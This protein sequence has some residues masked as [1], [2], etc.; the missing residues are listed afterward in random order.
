M[1]R[2]TIRRGPSGFT[3]VELLVVIGIIA[4]LISILLPALNKAR[5]QANSVKCA[6]NMR[7]IYTYVQ[8]YVQDNKGFLP[9]PPP[10][11]CTQAASV[12]PMGY[13]MIVAGTVDLTA[14]GLTEYMAPNVDARLALFNC[15]TDLADARPVSA[16][17]SITARNF[18]YSFN[19][20]LDYN[21]N[22]GYDDTF[23]SLPRH[24][25]I[26]IAQIRSAAAKILIFEEKW[27]NDG[28]CQITSPTSNTGTLDTNDVPADRHT[29]YGNQCFADGHVDRITPADFYA[30]VNYSG[31]VAIDVDW[32]HLLSY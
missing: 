25:T 15:P 8:M 11:S 29:G 26:N 21:F 23:A 3:L 4:M 32:F 9:I 30:H 2:G 27:P 19:G 31:N 18:T 6:S 24:Q 28:S 17:T 22:G 20:I 7:Q 5:E 10:I 16:L 14:G 13:Y 1:R 12:Y